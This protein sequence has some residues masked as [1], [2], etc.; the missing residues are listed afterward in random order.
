MLLCEDDAGVR[1]LA[2]RILERA[3]FEVLSA[4]SLAEVRPHLEAGP[5]RLDLLLTDVIMPDGSGHEVA[6][7]VTSSW[8]GTPVLYM[9]GYPADVISR[10]GVL[11]REVRFIEKP[12]TSE[13]LL[14]AVAATVC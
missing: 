3:G 8:P 2:T 13:E 10:Q 6:E 4:A 1:D 12:F 5:G 7:L 14:D 11:D 9:S